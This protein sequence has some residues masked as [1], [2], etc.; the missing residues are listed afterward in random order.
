M[1]PYLIMGIS[2]L[3]FLAILTWAITSANKIAIK[4]GFNKK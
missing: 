1:S 4:D 2:A 3:I